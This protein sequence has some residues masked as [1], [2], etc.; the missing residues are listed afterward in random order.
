MRT[1]NLVVG[2]LLVAAGGWGMQACAASDAA[3]ESGGETGAG[4]TVGT[5]FP[6]TQVSCACPGGTQGVPP[7]VMPVMIGSA[8]ILF[9]LA[10][11]H[12][13]GK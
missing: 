3:T 1:A 4:G 6:G 8:P 11:F 5:C 10:A 7:R 13:K 9:Y 2:V 12:V